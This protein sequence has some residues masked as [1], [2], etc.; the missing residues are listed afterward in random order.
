[1]YHI[2]EQEE[3]KHACVCVR[4]GMCTHMWACAHACV[5]VCV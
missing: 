5:H 2:K 3:V 1:M 4:V